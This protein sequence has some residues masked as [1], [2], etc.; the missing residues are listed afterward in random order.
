VYSSKVKS[1]VKIRKKSA[2][3]EITLAGGDRLT[4]QLQ[5]TEGERIQD[6]LNDLRNFIP[7]KP[8]D[9]T[10]KNQIIILNKNFI[11]SVIVFD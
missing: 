1:T 11:C 8:A 7:F 4:G 9:E 5:L 2:N 6:I 10:E 3:V